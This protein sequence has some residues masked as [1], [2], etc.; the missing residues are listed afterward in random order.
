MVDEGMPKNGVHQGARKDQWT[1]RN[2][3]NNDCLIYS[4]YLPIIMIAYGERCWIRDR[5]DLASGP[6]TRLDHS[7]SFV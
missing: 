6:V 4:Y 5:E 7:R 1:S 3:Y 2:A